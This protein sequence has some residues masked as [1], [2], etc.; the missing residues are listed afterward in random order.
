MK[1]RLIR[2]RYAAL[3]V[4]AQRALPSATAV[5]KV[6]ALITTRFRDPYC[7]TEDAR[8]VILR[9]D[10]PLPDGFDGERLPVWIAEARQQ[11][12]DDLMEQSTPVRRVPDRLRLGPEDMP[13]A[14]KGE[15]GW[16]N[17]ESVA[18]IIVNLGSLYVPGTDEKALREDVGDDLEP[19]ELSAAATADP[20]L[21]HEAET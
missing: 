17:A 14:L 15:E 6:T 8:K 21:E 5:N 7:S 2:E 11:A 9:D 10:Y 13:K 12:V 1:N 4:M 3:T 20:M 18:D 16:R 19:D